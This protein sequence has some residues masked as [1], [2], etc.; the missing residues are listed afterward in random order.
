MSDFAYLRERMVR[1]L[2]AEGGIRDQ[3]VLDAMLAV[4]RHLFVPKHLQARAYGNHALPIGRQQTISQPWAVARMTE[5]LRLGAEQTVLEIGT[6][7]GYQAAILAHLARRVYSLERI[8]DLAHQAIRRIR[9]LG[10]D[11]V[12]IQPI[13]GTLGWAE[14]APVERILVTAGAPSAPQPLLDQL[15]VGGVLVVPEGSRE[16]QRLVVYRRL[17]RG[18]QRTEK[19]AVSFVPLIG[20]HAWK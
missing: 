3:R 6:G 2:A 13:D 19:E 12:K 18:F 11:N 9:R 17:K 1:E 10:L 7:S 15:S 8:G 4:P 20:R 5:L 16:D 14:I